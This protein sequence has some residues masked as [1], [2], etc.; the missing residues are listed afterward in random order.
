MWMAVVLDSVAWSVDAAAMAALG[1]SVDW[2]SVSGYRDASTSTPSLWLVG[3]NGVTAYRSASGS[4]SPAPLPASVTANMTGVVAFAPTAV[5][6][7]GKSVTVSAVAV[8]DHC[9]VVWFVTSSSSWLLDTAACDTVRTAVGVSTGSTPSASSTAFVGV[10]VTSSGAVTAAAASGVVVSLAVGSLNANWTVLPFR[11]SATPAGINAVS[12]PAVAVAG[13]GTGAS[14]YAMSWTGYLERLTLDP[15]YVNVANFELLAVSQTP[16]SM[17]QYASELAVPPAM[18]SAAAAPSGRALALQGDMWHGATLSFQTTGRGRINLCGL[19]SVAITLRADDQVASA[20]NVYPTVSMTW[21]NGSNPSIPLSPYLV[22]SGSGRGASIAGAGVGSS[23]V[24]AVIP[25]RLLAPAATDGSFSWDAYDVDHMSIGN[26]SASCSDR[27]A[28]SAVLNPDCGSVYVSRIV[29]F[30]DAALIAADAAAAG[31]TVSSSQAA[32]V[33]AL[34]GTYEM[35]RQVT[36]YRDNLLATLPQSVTQ[37]VTGSFAIRGLTRTKKACTSVRPMMRYVCTHDA[38]LIGVGDGGVIVRRSGRTGRW[39]Q[40]VSPVT[41]Q[42]NA[43][44]STLTGHTIWAVGN[45]GTLI[46]NDDSV[47]GVST[48]TWRV[49][50]PADRPAHFVTID[51]TVSLYSLAM[52][53]NWVYAVGDNGT[54]AQHFAS[55]SATWGWTVTPGTAGVGVTLRG[56]SGSDTNEWMGWLMFVVVVGDGGVILHQVGTGGQFVRVAN[57]EYEV[58]GWC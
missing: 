1:T 53:D 38:D 43:V 10:T 34:A 11:S 55:V 36:A 40:D 50:S 24:T 54:V 49:F 57:P 4:W 37:S 56:V 42:L 14:L 46:I 58:F 12:G 44:L 21:W 8:G 45:A 3:S 5:G 47:T 41:T 51:P 18:A 15:G 6:V 25:L 2:L 28:P 30:R 52:A 32:A 33:R 20:G 19:T 27:T 16:L 23:W 7:N 29:F 9:V 31:S 48:G 26:L 35:C 39:T 13:R 22:S 17:L